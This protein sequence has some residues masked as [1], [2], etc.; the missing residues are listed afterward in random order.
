MDKVELFNVKNGLYGDKVGAAEYLLREFPNK[1]KLQIVGKEIQLVEYV[2]K[3]H[4]IEMVVIDVLN[5][6]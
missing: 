2:N 6:G 5:K 1:Y 4:S 3:G